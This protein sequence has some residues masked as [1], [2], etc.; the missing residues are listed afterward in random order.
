MWESEA[1]LTI[2]RGNRAVT[3]NPVQSRGL[4]QL[5]TQSEETQDVCFSTIN[6]H[7]HIHSFIYWW[8]NDWLIDWLIQKL[9][10]KDPFIDS[11]LNP[12]Q[13]SHEEHV[14]KIHKCEL[15]PVFLSS[16]RSSSSTNVSHFSFWLKACKQ[17]DMLVHSF[18]FSVFKHDLNLMKTFSFGSHTWTQ[19]LN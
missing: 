2:C 9:Q 14:R 5:C 15:N 10:L 8:I 11:T 13:T 3:H 17:R 4:D 7:G 18:V 16:H 12:G 19:L 6:N 1:S